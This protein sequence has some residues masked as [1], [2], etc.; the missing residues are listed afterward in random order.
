MYLTKGNKY[1]NEYQKKLIAIAETINDK[2]K[3]SKFVNQIIDYSN[4]QKQIEKEE[5]K[6]NEEE[7]EELHNIESKDEDVDLKNYNTWIKCK[8]GH[9]VISKSEKIIDD[10]LHDNKIRHGYDMEIDNNTNY[11]YDFKLF[12]YGD[13]Y[14]EHWGFKDR[15]NYKE[16]KQLKTE[17]YKTNNYILIE[18][19]EDS[20]KNPNYLK[21]ALRKAIPDIFKK[22]RNN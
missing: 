22:N 7:I 4:N 3:N 19:D 6:I 1:K 15:K 5:I 9:R 13:V 17:Y 12:D 11:R 10:F 18:S 20:I 14:I 2:Y 21:E 16:R 8:D